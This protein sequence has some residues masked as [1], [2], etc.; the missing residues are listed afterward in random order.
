VRIG[1]RLQMGTHMRRW[2]I[3]A[4]LAAL[5]AGCLQSDVPLAP[6]GSSARSK[7]LVGVWRCLSPNMEKGEFMTATV[8]PFDQQQLLLELKNSREA[9]VFRYRFYP[10]REGK[11]VVWN[12]Q[13]LNP[14]GDG[15]WSFARILL[16][17]SSSL[18]ARVI[19]ESALTGSTDAEK[20]AD[21][22]A[23]SA[24][25]SIYGDPFRCERSPPDAR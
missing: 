11:T 23:R 19:Q 14:E 9:G 1:I 21:A 5:L 7:A 3:L 16:A 15:K 12:A 4:I 13:E 22:R 25:D 8:L 2:L 18:I 17:S 6:P 20:L 10:S 24:D